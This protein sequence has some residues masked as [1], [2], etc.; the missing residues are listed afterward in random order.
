M[1]FNNAYSAKF[2]HK[3]RTQRAHS[4]PFRTVGIQLRH[5]DVGLA[6][7]G[8]NGLLMVSPY[9][10]HRNPGIWHDPE[11]EAMSSEQSVRRGGGAPAAL[12]AAF[13][14]G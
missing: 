5:E 14:P 6:A 7:K 8:L 10:I 13:T 1:L 11:L 2:Q 9:V 4:L 3:S 12:I